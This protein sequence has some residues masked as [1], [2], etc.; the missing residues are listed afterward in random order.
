LLEE[1][2]TPSKETS[3]S[4]AQ[5]LNHPAQPPHGL[6]APALGARSQTQAHPGA[7]CIPLG[8]SSPKGRELAGLRAAQSLC[9]QI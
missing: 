9:H 6:P 3:P 4:C 7:S 5:A 1:K 8:F 2:L